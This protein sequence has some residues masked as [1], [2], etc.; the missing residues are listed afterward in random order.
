[1]VDTL[2]ALGHTCSASVYLHNQRLYHFVDFDIG[3]DHEE[4]AY[5]LARMDIHCLRTV[6]TS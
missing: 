4:P 5:A 6:P 2:Y 3:W 1:M